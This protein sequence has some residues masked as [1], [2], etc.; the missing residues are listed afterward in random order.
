MRLDNYIK[1]LLLQYDCVVVPDFGGFVCTFSPA[2]IHPVQHRFTPPG[3]KISFNKLLKANDGLLIHH[4]AITNG[5]SYEEAHATVFNEV[6]LWK[7]QLLEKKSV[8]LQDIGSIYNDENGNVLFEQDS[9]FNFLKESFG[10]SSFHSLPIERDSTLKLVHD[11]RQKE[12]ETN[13]IPSITRMAKYSVAA[14][15]LS[16]VALTTYKL[17]VFENI[18]TDAISLNPFKTESPVYTVRE[19]PEIK[20]EEIDEKSTVK[21]EIENS[22]EEVL[23]VNIDNEGSLN[24]R[25]RDKIVK[26]KTKVEIGRYH[27]VGGCFGVESNADKMLNKLLKLGYKAD[28]SVSHNGLKVVSYQSFN[29]KIEAQ[30]FLAKIKNEQNKQAWL[31]VK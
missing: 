16:I 1:D 19:Y 12:I 5:I 24:V 22:D 18:P 6:S 9:K 15:I 29:N 3:K 27:V 11:G 30:E 20:V 17:N 7:S 28:A 10:L 21:D 23:T 25:L 4:V 8:I 26:D 31:L 13:V 14:A 2:K